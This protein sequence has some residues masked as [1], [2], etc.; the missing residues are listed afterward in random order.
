MLLYAQKDSATG[1]TNVS[2]YS[3]RINIDKLN[4]SERTRI[5]IKMKPWRLLRCLSFPSAKPWFYGTSFA[6]IIY[7]REQRIRTRSQARCQDYIPNE[8]QMKKKYEQKLDV[9]FLNS[10]IVIDID[11]ENSIRNF[12]ATASD[13]QNRIANLSNEEILNCSNLY[14]SML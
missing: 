1:E 5:K 2:S 14:V 9:I 6:L 12:L 13:I 11:T 4:I 3:V 10:S 7:L 8:F